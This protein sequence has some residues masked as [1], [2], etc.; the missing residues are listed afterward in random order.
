[1]LEGLYGAQSRQ[2]LP[3]KRKR[4]EPIVVDDDESGREETR[5]EVKRSAAHHK[6][7]GIIGD[8]I[9]EGTQQ[10]PVSHLPGST[11]IGQLLI[12]P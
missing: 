9:R 5:N 6:G 4:V 7:T 3:Q 2:D 8:Y 1:M 11:S 10:G 12:L